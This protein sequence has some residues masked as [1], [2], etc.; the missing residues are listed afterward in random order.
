MM[1]NQLLWFS[2]RERE[3]ES[4]RR[5]RKK[6]LWELLK[7]KESTNAKRFAKKKFRISIN[8]KLIEKFGRDLS[9]IKS[10][11]FADLHLIIDSAD[12]ILGHKRKSSEFTR[13]IVNLYRLAVAAK[14]MSQS[15]EKSRSDAEKCKQK[16]H[17]AKFSKKF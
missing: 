14:V 4:R 12:N 5:R 8:L 17:N 3:R 11:T 15:L 13:K 6:Y 9:G 16:L 7:D 1:N 2:K 10:E